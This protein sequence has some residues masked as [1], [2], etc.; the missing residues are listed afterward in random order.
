ME[1]KEKQVQDMIEKTLKGSFT[2]RRIG[3]TP[4]DNLQL[5]PRKYVN[6]YGSVLGRPVSSVTGQQ[7]FDTSIGRPIYRRGDGAWVDGAG[8]VS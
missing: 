1:L 5:V 4:A 7:Y 8:S 3:D 6:M 2:N